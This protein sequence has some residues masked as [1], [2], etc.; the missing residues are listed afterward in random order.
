MEQKSVQFKWHNNKWAKD[1]LNFKDYQHVEVKCQ[2]K[3]TF[4]NKNYDKIHSK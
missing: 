4:N 1:K 3:S 2:R